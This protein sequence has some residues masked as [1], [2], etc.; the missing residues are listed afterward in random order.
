MPATRGNLR[1]VRLNGQ[2]DTGPSTFQL[3]HGL[4]HY[5]AHTMA[6]DAAEEKK[7]HRQGFSRSQLEMMGKIVQ[8]YE[9]DFELQGMMGRPDY[10][11]DEHSIVGPEFL[12]HGTQ[13]DWDTI[14]DSGGLKSQGT[15]PS[16]SLHVLSSSANATGYVSGTRV[17]SVAKSF[18]K[19]TGWVYLIYAPQGIAVHST[20]PHKQAEVAAIDSVPIKDIFMFKLLTDPNLIYINEDFRSALKS[21]A[22]LDRCLRLLGGG[23]YPQGL[24]WSDVP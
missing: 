24:F 5:P 22:N 14:Y 1:K 10:I 13:T 21:T 3:D 23:T 11:D 6:R 20:S 18:A 7:L 8:Y 12:L 2:P 19:S 15:N 9:T 4:S 17:L 16:A